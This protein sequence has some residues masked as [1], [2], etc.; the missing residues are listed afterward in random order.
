MALAL[1]LSEHLVLLAT[2]QTPSCWLSHIAGDQ[3]DTT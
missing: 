2:R 1:I 3:S